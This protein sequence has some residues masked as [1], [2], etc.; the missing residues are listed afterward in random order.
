MS[1]TSKQQHQFSD[2]YFPQYLKNNNTKIQNPINP[3]NK[4]TK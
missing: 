2:G 1:G 4:I 3:F